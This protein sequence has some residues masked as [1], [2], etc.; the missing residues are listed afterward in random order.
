MR[1]EIYPHHPRR[2][3]LETAMRLLRCSSESTSA[4]ANA[5]EL[6]RFANTQHG[7]VSDVVFETTLLG[8]TCTIVAVLVLDEPVAASVAGSCAVTCALLV[9]AIC[10]LIYV[11]SLVPARGDAPSLEEARR[12]SDHARY[13]M[14]SQH[15]TATLA[16]M[17]GLIALAHT[18]FPCR[19]L[20]VALVGAMATVL[21]RL[22]LLP[23]QLHDLRQYVLAL[24]IRRIERQTRAD[25]DAEIAAFRQAAAHSAVSEP[26]S[27][28]EK[29]WTVEV[30]K[31]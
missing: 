11:M 15:V 6:W 26:Q 14:W 29:G 30:L 17:T 3:I 31:P 8:A 16:V 12:F 2:V 19:A 7:S 18:A 10:G 22:A 5:R 24:W 1:E 21:A 28:V 23:L 20:S 13:F 27:V 4:F 9:P 25:I